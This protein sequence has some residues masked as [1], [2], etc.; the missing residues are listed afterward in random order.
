MT[1]MAAIP[2]AAIAGIAGM[3]L[4]TPVAQAAI[5]TDG[6]EI[7]LDGFRDT[8]LTG[9]FLVGPGVD[10]YLLLA[11]TLTGTESESR[12]R[13]ASYGGAAMGFI[14][15]ASSSSGT[16]QVEWWGLVAPAEGTHLLQVSL[17]GRAQQ[18][19]ATLISFRGVE[20]RGSVGR[21]VATRGGAGPSLVTIPGG[22]GEVILDG[23]CGWGPDSV[24]LIAGEGQRAHWHWSSGSL[25]TAGSAR[26]AGADDRT[27]SWTASGPGGMEWAATGLSLRP[28]GLG[29][30]LPLDV[31]TAGCGVAAGHHQV[32]SPA[33]SALAVLCS[34]L[35]LWAARRRASRAGSSPGTSP[36]RSRETGRSMRPTTSRLALADDSEPDL[37]EVT[38][39]RAKVG[40]ARAQAVIVHRYQRPIYSLLWRM[41]GPEREVVQDL[42]Q[43]TFLRVLRALA[44]FEYDGRA[45]LITWI[46]TIATRL[47]LDHIRSSRPRT[48]LA[49]VP[50]GVP[51]TLPRPDQEADRHQ[52]AGALV[53]AVDELSPPFRAAF[54]LREVHGLTYDEISV[55]LR[56]DVGTVRSRLNRARTALQSALSEM[57]DA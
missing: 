10:R 24:L 42:T 43:E 4:A 54:L 45:R 47:A 57:H 39:A 52:L 40:D 5:A 18:S 12:V 27:L 35:G 15:R 49:S 44:R 2:C 31:E 28:A 46:L 21:F 34:L 23:V 48:D 26:D 22:P 14:G 32:A 30:T 11:V 1:S 19:G 33:G 17:T 50:G 29:L 51:V 56:I 3:L 55:A 53:Q 20:P 16:C 38:L 13:A 7:F 36:G 9:D 6:S 25:S 41:V 37:D 8:E